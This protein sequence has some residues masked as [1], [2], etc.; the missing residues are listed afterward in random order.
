MQAH[1][2]RRESCNSDSSPEPSAACLEVGVLGEGDRDFG[3]RGHRQ[4]AC[5]T[6]RWL[7]R[8]QAGCLCHFGDRGW[9]RI[10]SRLGGNPERCSGRVWG[11]PSERGGGVV[12]DPERGSGLVYGVPLGHGAVL[13]EGRG[14]GS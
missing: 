8:S 11:V 14:E 6:L 12:G 13:G 3:L 5:A 1:S 2:V 4:D 9:T 10:V 7:V